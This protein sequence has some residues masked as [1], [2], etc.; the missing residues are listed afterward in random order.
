VTRPCVHF[1]WFRGDEYARAVAIWGQPDYVHHG[2]DLRARRD[3]QDGDTVV[4]ARGGHDQAPAER[5]YADL[6]GV[7]L[8]E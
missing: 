4:F 7:K 3:T 8:P 5:S 6:P 1:V 2:Y